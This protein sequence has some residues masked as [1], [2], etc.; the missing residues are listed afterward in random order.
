VVSAV[1]IMMFSSLWLGAQETPRVEVFGGYALSRFRG[2]L[3]VAQKHSTLNGWDSE[4][5]FNVTSNLGLVAD[6][7]GSY[8]TPKTLPFTQ[9]VCLDCPITTPGSEFPTRIYTF[10]FGPQVSVRKGSFRPF[11]HALFGGAHLGLDLTALNPVLR[12]SS[13]DSSSGFALALGG[14]LD[15]LVTER[16]AWRVQMDYLSADLNNLTHKDF[17]VATGVVFRF[18]AHYG[19]GDRHSGGCGTGS[20]ALASREFRMAGAVGRGGGL[21]DTPR[22]LMGRKQHCPAADSRS[23]QCA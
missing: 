19:C 18:G 10:M 22:A 16:V 6:F 8:G 14:G 3:G 17:R 9:F 7:G 20:I 15:T 1:L 4:L 21:A 23:G 12:A 13:S 5:I 2:A 11:G